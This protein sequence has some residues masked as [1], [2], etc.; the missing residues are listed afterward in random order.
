MSRRQRDLSERFD[1]IA[2]QVAL[3]RKFRLEDASLHRRAEMSI[4]F[5]TIPTRIDSIPI[6]LR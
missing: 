6:G 4:D 3:S 5:V 2:W 1:V